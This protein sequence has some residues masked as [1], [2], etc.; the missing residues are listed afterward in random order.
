MIS[1]GWF[2]SVIQTEPSTAQTVLPATPTLTLKVNGLHPTPPIVF[3]TGP[4]AL[5]LDVGAST[6]TAPLLSYW[7]IIVNGHVFWVTASGVQA[8]PAP[9]AFGP[10][11]A[12]VNVPL[13]NITQPAG[14]VLTNVF[15]LVD[16]GGAIV[17]ADAI[18]SIRP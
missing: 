13:M 7:A 9:L 15:L 18:V 17:A 2:S 4:L 10:P 3:T 5:T 16:S 6:Y 12:A 11:V 8:T 14:T 1:R